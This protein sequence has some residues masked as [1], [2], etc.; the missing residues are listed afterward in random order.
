VNVPGT[1]FQ[2]LVD[3]LHAELGDIVVEGVGV[4]LN[5][6]DVSE[7]IIFT[8]T[9]ERRYTTQPAYSINTSTQV[10]NLFTSLF[11]YC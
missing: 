9:V 7:C 8:L 4:V 11:T 1:A 5:Q 2:R 6:F 3:K 10:I